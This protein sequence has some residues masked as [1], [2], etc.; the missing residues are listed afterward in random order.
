MLALGKAV[1]LSIHD[2][3]CFQ[4]WNCPRIYTWTVFRNIV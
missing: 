4:K 1:R 3:I 2:V